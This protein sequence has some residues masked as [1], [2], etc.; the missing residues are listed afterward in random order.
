METKP[1]FELEQV[2]TAK[3]EDGEVTG[4]LPN[5]G[6]HHVAANWHW[7]GDFLSSQ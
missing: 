3:I 2:H 6:G 5:G 1:L 7:K 4:S